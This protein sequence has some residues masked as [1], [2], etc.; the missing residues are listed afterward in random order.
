MRFQSVKAPNLPRV[1]AVVLHRV[2]IKGLSL[3]GLGVSGDVPS[4]V[5]PSN[6]CN[7]SAAVGQSRAS[8]RVRKISKKALF[9]S[10]ETQNLVRS[11]PT[12]QACDKVKLAINGCQVVQN[13]E[14][15]ASGSSRTVASAATQQGDRNTLIQDKRYPL[16]LRVQEDKST[17]QST[18]VEDAIQ[19]TQI[20][21]SP[22]TRGSSATKRE[23]KGK[24]GGPRGKISVCSGHKVRARASEARRKRVV[25]TAF[26]D[27]S[28][29]VSDVDTPK[30]GVGSRNRKR[31]GTRTA[32][33]IPPTRK[34]RL[35]SSEDEVIHNVSDSYLQPQV[36]LS[37]VGAE[38]HA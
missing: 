26:L 3:P 8:G 5:K 29:E 23:L 11:K 32:S 37:V 20:C 34:R 35:S 12:A 22:L 2:N 25:S 30:E 10:A 28:D 24:A 16:S 27:S 21:S 13:S 17:C 9:N 4:V 7:H 33:E 18:G 14:I 38:S 15:F 6:H 36:G 1:P 19:H 31:R